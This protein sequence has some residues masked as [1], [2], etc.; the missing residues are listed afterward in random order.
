MCPKYRTLHMGTDMTMMMMMIIVIV[1]I[2]IIIII[3]G[4]CGRVVVNY[5]TN[6]RVAGSIPDEVIF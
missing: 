4:A 6:R 2:I 3:I 5:A 1:I